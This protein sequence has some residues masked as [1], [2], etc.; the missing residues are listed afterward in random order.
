MFRL[1]RLQPLLD[2]PRIENIMITRH[3]RVR[4]EYDDGTL[5]DVD[6]VA[7]SDQELAEFLAFVSARSDNPRPFDP[8]NPKLHLKLDDG[9]RLAADLHTAWISVVIRRHRIRKVTLDDLVEWGTLSPVVADFLRAA[10]R[11]KKSIV[12]SGE[13]GVGK[14]TLVRALCAE[15]DPDE[16]IGTFETEYELFLHELYDQHKVVHAW[17]AR[18]GSGERGPDGRIAGERTNDEQIRDSFRFT[19]GRQ[20]LGE[21]RGAEAWQMV[22]L[23]ES[24]AGSISTTHAANAQATMRKLVTCAMQAGPQVSMEL[25]AAKL[26]DVIDLV[27]HLT[28]DIVPAATGRLAR[29]NRYVSEILE[30]TPGE[31]P[32]GFATTTVFAPVPGRCAVAHTRPDSLWDDLIAKGLNAL[33]FERELGEHRR[34]P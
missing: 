26:A 3:D 17:E 9:S 19:L 20:I 31:H 27:V 29:K 5:E 18:S 15:I 8:A 32:R 11:A 34:Q 13:Q 30:V 12:V 21:I 10:V 14:T 23:M 7:D 24:G 6:P 2:N 22:L 28:C 4:V 16:P 1:G 25:A 33:G